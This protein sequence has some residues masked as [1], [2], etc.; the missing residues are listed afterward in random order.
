M[1]IKNEVIHKGKVLS[2]FEVKVKTFVDWY[3]ARHRKKPFLYQVC[4][5]VKSVDSLVLR[6]LNKLYGQYPN[7]LIVTTRD[8][9]LADLFEDGLTL[10]EFA[11]KIGK[12]RDHVANH[13]K[14]MERLGIVFKGN[15]NPYNLKK[16]KYEP[17]EED[18][19]VVYI[20]VKSGLFKGMTGYIESITDTVN[21]VIWLGT[22]QRKTKL[23]TCEYDEIKKVV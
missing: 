10:S 16:D 7:S 11:K 21:A 14:G 19:P 8:K 18:G 4:D 13:K 20:K 15:R 22:R 6:A 12:N 2:A 9:K 3:E 5:E 1:R 23:E 17:V